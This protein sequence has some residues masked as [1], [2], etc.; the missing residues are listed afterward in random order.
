VDDHISGDD[1]ADRNGEAKPDAQFRIR[2]ADDVRF[3]R[4]P[5]L[6]RVRSSIS[7]FNIPVFAA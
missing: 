7:A 4:R 5:A 3:R 6:V 2:P 1:D